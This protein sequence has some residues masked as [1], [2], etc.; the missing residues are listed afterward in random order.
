MSAHLWWLIGWFIIAYVLTKFRK[1]KH[2]VDID[3]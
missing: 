3:E 2:V 1:T